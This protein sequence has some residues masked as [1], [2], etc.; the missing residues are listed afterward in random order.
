M[1]DEQPTSPQ[2]ATSPVPTA[3]RIMGGFYQR[4]ERLSSENALWGSRGRRPERKGLPVGALPLLVSRRCWT[5][6]RQLWHWAC[7]ASVAA[8]GRQK[9][10]PRTARFTI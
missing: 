8:V 3:R 10:P 2:A 4:L 5:V 1:G 7:C 6:G 9:A